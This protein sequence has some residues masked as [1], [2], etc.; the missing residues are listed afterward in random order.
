[1][2]EHG[3]M[4]RA[5]L[6]RAILAGQ[7]TETRRLLVPSAV[8]VVERDS[9]RRA[10]RPQGFADLLARS[11]ARTWYGEPSISLPAH[12]DLAALPRVQAGDAL[13]VRETWRTAA[14]LDGKTCAQI[15]E[16][17]ENAHYREPWAPIWYEADGRKANADDIDVD[18]GGWSWT[19]RPAVHLPRWACRLV[20]PVVEVRVERLRQLTDDDARA[21]GCES[22]DDFARLWDSLAPSGATWVADPLVLVY[23]WEPVGGAS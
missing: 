2:T 10:P 8:F 5:E 3:M 20:L 23:R 13:W 17:C 1:M 12:P 22:R 15:A 9:G 4:F 6:V 7:K 21:E 16:A 14:D 19:A 11:S 18:W